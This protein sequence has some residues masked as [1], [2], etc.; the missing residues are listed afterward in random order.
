MQAMTRI[1][2][3]LAFAAVSAAPA[4]AHHPMGGATP[5]TAFEGLVSGLA[6]PVIGLDHL[7]FLIG[8]GLLAA[9]YQNGAWLPVAFLTGSALG[10][11][12]QLSGAGL[13]A[14]EVVVVIS[15]L[16]MAAAL[17]WQGP[18]T[19]TT[20][21][22]CFALSGIFHGYAL[23][24]PVVEATFTPVIAYL[25]GLVIIQCSISIGLMLLYR[26]ACAYR[27]YAASRAQVA[28]ASAALA[29]GTISLLQL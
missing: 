8:V 13:P 12:F 27:P 10:S 2:L 11:A 14:A 19:R 25:I 24:E 4:A 26:R 6:H 22:A 28:V 5:A 9:R 7:A 23:A 21:A 1:L 17:L 3:S 15:I 16:I 18:I 20:A 29:I